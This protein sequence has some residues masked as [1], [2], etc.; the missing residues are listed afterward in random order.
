[1]NAKDNSL[2]DDSIDHVEFER[3]YKCNSSETIMFNNT[4][5][6]GTNVTLHVSEMQVQVFQ[7]KNTTGEFGNG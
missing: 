7:F 6:D 2:F 5:T 3:S 4:M 1:M